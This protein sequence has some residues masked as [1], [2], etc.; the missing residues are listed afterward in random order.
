[1][2]WDF[3]IRQILEVASVGS[4]GKRFYPKEKE[5]ESL[6]GS[7]MI[8]EERGSGAMPPEREGERGNGAMPPD[9]EGSQA[10]PRVFSMLM[11]GGTQ[12][13]TED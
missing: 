5:K 11:G 4:G 1:M 2:Y 6:D 8:P 13:S 12:L 7:W 9:R 10:Q 3:W